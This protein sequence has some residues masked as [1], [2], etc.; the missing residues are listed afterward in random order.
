MEASRNGTYKVSGAES[1]GFKVDGKDVD[2]SAILVSVETSCSVGKIAVAKIVLQDNP[3]SLEASDSDSFPIGSKVEISFGRG[4]DRSV[5]F[6]GMVTDRALRF[7]KQGAEVT[8]IDIL[9]DIYDVRLKEYRLNKLLGREGFH[10]SRTDITDFE[11]LE[12]LFAE[13]QYD[14]VINIAGIPGVRLSMENPWLYLNVNTGGTLNLLEC[15]RRYDVGKFIQASTS[16]IYGENA[17]ED[18][19]RELQKV[20]DAQ[21]EPEKFLLTQMFKGLYQTLWNEDAVIHFEINRK[22]G[23]YNYELLYNFM[24]YASDE[25]YIDEDV[26]MTLVGIFIRELSPE[27]CEGFPLKKIAEGLQFEGVDRSEKFSA[28]LKKEFYNALIRYRGITKLREDIRSWLGELDRKRAELAQPD[29]ID[30]L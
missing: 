10:F 2:C 15:C 26:D 25:R 16:S 17:L 3:T 4:G 20:A 14:A 12:K 5:V 30:S 29:F 24:L 13:N 19:L 11:A 27:Y 1:V 28:E 23:R 21:D 8:G 18:G 7:D 22:N 9:N 6:S